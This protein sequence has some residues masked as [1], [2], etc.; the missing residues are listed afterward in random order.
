VLAKYQRPG[1][2]VGG[3]G[4][5]DRV[6]EFIAG[7]LLVTALCLVYPAIV[8]CSEVALAT[9]HLVT[10]NKPCIV[11]HGVVLAAGM[12]S[13]IHASLRKVGIIKGEE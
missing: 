8:A 1:D 7:Q 13:A 10:D 2:F 12:V 9:P 3:S 4:N 5:T 6:C 11:C